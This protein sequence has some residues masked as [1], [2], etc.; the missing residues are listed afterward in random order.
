[1]GNVER[2]TVTTVRWIAISLVV[3]GLA[4]LAGCRICADCEALAYPAYGGAWQRTRRDAGRVGSIFDP[5]GAKTSDLVSRDT[6]TDPDELER[7]R[8]KARG[9][10]K[11]PDPNDR[12]MDE[13][14][15]VPD[16]KD[17]GDDLRNRSLEDIED[18]GNNELREKDLRDI[19]VH[20]IPGRQ[21]P[22][23]LR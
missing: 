6:P 12:K 3:I 16:V 15:D 14:D 2:F 18:D 8:Q 5:G 4:P 1:M 19:D 9:A 10:G 13:T 21:L 7:V 23:L 17:E 20:I 11:G 22:P